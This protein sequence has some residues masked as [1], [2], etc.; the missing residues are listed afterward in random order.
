MDEPDESEDNFFEAM[1]YMH[2][3]LDEEERNSHEVKVWNSSSSSCGGDSI[4]SV[5]AL[6]KK[7][8]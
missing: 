2:L 5:D 8:N 1:H 4:H 3:L 6:D 7:E